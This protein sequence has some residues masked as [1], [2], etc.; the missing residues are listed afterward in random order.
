LRLILVGMM[1][2]SHK[3]IF[4]KLSPNIYKAH[5]TLSSI[6]EQHILVYKHF[7]KLV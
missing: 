1:R 3:H 2:L 4:P 5:S 6:M 7:C